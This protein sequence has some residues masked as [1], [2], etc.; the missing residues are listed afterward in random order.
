MG[1]EFYSSTICIRLT[2]RRTAIDPLFLSLP[3]FRNVIRDL[4][5]PVAS[6]ETLVNPRG[7]DHI[8]SFLRVPDVRG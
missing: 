7:R 1:R 2:R 8:E 6:R 4:D 3:S 5:D